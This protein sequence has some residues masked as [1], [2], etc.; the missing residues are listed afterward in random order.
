MISGK[1][2][3]KGELFFEIGLIAADEE[4]IP[5]K[6]LL[7]TGFY[8]WLIVNS[9]DAENLDWLLTSEQKKV[10]TA[11]GETA[12]DIYEGIVLIDGEEFIIPVLV[13]EEIEEIILGVRWLRTKR[14]VADFRAGVLTLG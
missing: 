2:N 14:L 7:D 1:F 10:L 3:R 11:G 6:A 5:V 4:V 13:G 9:Q 8:G 12:F